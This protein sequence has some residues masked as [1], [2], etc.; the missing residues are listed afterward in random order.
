MI[1]VS[2]IELFPGTKI[3]PPVL[4]HQ[5]LENMDDCKAVLVITMNKGDEVD[6]AM[7]CMS[8]ANL[9]FM[10]VKMQMFV[11]SMVNGD[12]HE[13]GRIFGPGA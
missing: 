13:R 6:I 8:L 3:S 2:D 9:S 4:L 5:S 7:S 10:L 12:P 1:A 11:A